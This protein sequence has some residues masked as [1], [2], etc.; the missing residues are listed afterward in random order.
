MLRGGLWSL[1]LLGFGGEVLEV[2]DCREEERGVWPELVSPGY[3]RRRNKVQAWHQLFKKIQTRQQRAAV[4]G[5]HEDGRHGRPD[6][7]RELADAGNQ[8]R[9]RADQID[10]DRCLRGVTPS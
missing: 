8:K 1:L 10:E 3:R 4:E 2:L 7:V 6:D 9:H 5:F